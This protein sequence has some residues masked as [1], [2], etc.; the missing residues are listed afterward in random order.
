MGAQLVNCFILL[1]NV[2]T[3]TGAN[4]IQ[5]TQEGDGP[6]NPIFTLATKH[7][8]KT[9]FNDWFGSISEANSHRIRC[10]P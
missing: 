4:W 8:E 9:Q 5:G 10:C 2:H 6:A 7:N 1:H 3:I